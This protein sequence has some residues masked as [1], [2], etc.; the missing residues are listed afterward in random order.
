[1]TVQWDEITRVITLTTAKTKISL[2]IDSKDALIN[3]V[4]SSLEQSATI[5]NNTTMVPLRFIAGNMDQTV[6]FD[7]ATQAI[8]ITNKSIQPVTVK[9]KRDKPTVDNLSIPQIDTEKSNVKIKDIISDSNSHIY[10]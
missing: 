1:M 5:L 8:T 7:S 6:S 4:S 3:G 9:E 2:A 10:I